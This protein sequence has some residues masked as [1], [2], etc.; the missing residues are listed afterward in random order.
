M[1]QTIQTL[2]AHLRMLVQGQNDALII[3]LLQ[4][5]AESERQS[6]GLERRYDTIAETK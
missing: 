4:H 2:E 3:D 6:N 5:N 1:R